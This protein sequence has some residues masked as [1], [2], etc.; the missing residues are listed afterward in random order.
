[1]LVLFNVREGLPE[2]LVAQLEDCG[3]GLVGAVA[4][5]EGDTELVGEV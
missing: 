5:S 2:W 1:M 3:A 4:L